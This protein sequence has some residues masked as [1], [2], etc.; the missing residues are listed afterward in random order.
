MLNKLKLIK[1]NT[2]LN[3]SGVEQWIENPLVSG[4]IPLLDTLNFL[5]SYVKTQY[6]K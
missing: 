5:Q 1:T 3:S 6:P 4:S 2:S